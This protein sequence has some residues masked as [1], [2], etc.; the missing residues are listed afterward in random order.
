VALKFFFFK[1]GK[2]R[3]EKGGQDRKKHNLVVGRRGGYKKRTGREAK[4]E[5]K[6]KGTYYKNVRK[7]K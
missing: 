7:I 1:D 2:S 4:M 6:K 5:I 3:R